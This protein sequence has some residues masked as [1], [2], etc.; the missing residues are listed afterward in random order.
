VIGRI[1]S[2]GTAGRSAG[3]GW[4]FAFGGWWALSCGRLE[5]GA[6]AIGLP[7]LL[8]WNARPVAAGGSLLAAHLLLGLCYRGRHTHRCRL[9]PIVLP[10]VVV[11]AVA[12]SAGLLG[13][14]VA[15]LPGGAV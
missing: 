11:A 2:A 12:G 10:L 14:L 6:A 1:E 4:A 13:L 5:A 7:F 15:L 3:C 9:E 8:A